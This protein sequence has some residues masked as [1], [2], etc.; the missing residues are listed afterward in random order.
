MRTITAGRGWVVAVAL[1]GIVSMTNA[2]LPVHKTVL[3][4]GLTILVR[5]DHSA[6]VVTAQAWC[7]AGSITEGKYLGAG[8]SHVL[9]HML[10]KGTTTRG[11]AEI[12]QEIQRKGGYMNAYTSFE[13][14]VYYISLPSENWQ[15]A[16][17]ILADCM[18]NATIPDE[19]LLKE[20]EVILRE[21]AMGV[22]DPG[23]RSNK[24]M[25]NAA[26]LT[27]PY[28]FPVI[29]YPDIYNRITR[30]DVVAYYKKMYV[31]NNLIFIIVGAVQND[32]VVARLKELTKDFKMN[33]VEPATI[34]VEP[35]QVSLR[36]RYEEAPVQLSNI[37]LAWHIPAVTHADVPALDVLGLVAGQGRSSR[38]YREVQQ[39]LG[40]VH[41]ISSGAYTPGHPGLFVVSAKA[42]A[43][44]RDDAI[45]A[46]RQEVKKLL[47]EPITP[48]ECAKAI[49]NFVSDHYEKLKT[50]EG[51]AADIGH[52][53]FLVGDPNFS[54]TYLAAVRKV[55]PADV[56]T[57]AR[58]YLTD[59]NL[60]I[61]ALSPT[62]TNP[63]KDSATAG[64]SEL[65]IQ[66]FDLPN[67]LRILVREDPKLPLVDIQALCKGGVIAETPA[68]NGVTKLTARILVKG[69][70]TRTADQIAETVESLGAD[71][72]GFA[73]NNSFGVSARA[74]TEDLDQ[75]LDLFADVLINPIFPDDKLTRERS[76]QL[77]E[78]KA[79]Q[80][81]VL[82]SCQQLLRETMY[83]K[84]PY[85][86]NALGTPAT[87][88]KLTRTDLADFHRRY[89]VPNNIVIA[90]FGNV[91]AA[92][93]RK[94]LESKF[95]ALKPGQP[96]FNTGGAE[97]L[98]AAAR[99]VAEKN[100]EQAVL[101]IGYSSAD[102]F[103]PDRYALDLLNEVYSG[104]GSRLFIRLRDELSL[105]YYTGAFQLLGL[106][107][108]FFAFYVGTTP[109][110][111]ELCEK[112]IFAE[113]EKLKTTG[114]T[115]EELD[116][117][118]AS[119]IG[120]RKVQMQ[121]NGQLAMTVGL[122]ELYGLGYENFRTVEAKYRAVTLDEIKRIANAYFA[123]K[124]SGVAVVRPATKGN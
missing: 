27:H 86:F 57:I 11:V 88:A 113:V 100:K 21:M 12:P 118:K 122:D 119:L 40:L 25:W 95:G 80:D 49:K 87:L 75:I 109:D 35:P 2:Q 98:T 34:P 111:V 112:E 22:D 24:L 63:K 50:V 39:K 52:N 79:E 69:T 60:T 61:T 70:K 43:D 99:K 47:A 97:R 123:G 51:Q 37:N 48:A 77:S 91:K 76:V 89:A 114:L 55:T 10:F 36:E 105:C 28:R 58:K 45:T 41:S 103:S 64:K 78:L 73:G 83:T 1:L 16:T 92:D 14:T 53:E 82:R 121:D 74:M 18:M 13:Q 72:N 96:E 93:I 42:D 3:D 102:I 84:H 4:N 107:P 26:Y 30:D 46:I 68:N 81:Q 117:A 66:K 115:D 59:D 71:L 6:P 106:E 19:E 31:P 23:R 124:P 101:L 85:R 62:G 15:T 32:A 65:T 17:D 5:E 29:G 20:K 9:E 94:K 33:T 90:V 38:L 44:K 116:R 56:L 67:G 7:R 108:G 54:E 120:Q 8:I 104:L 110:K